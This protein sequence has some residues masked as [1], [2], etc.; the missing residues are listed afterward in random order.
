MWKQDEKK[1]KGKR[2]KE[3]NDFASVGWSEK[4][5]KVLLNTSEEDKRE[6]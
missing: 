3:A 6:S 2:D 4:R 5:K 1:R